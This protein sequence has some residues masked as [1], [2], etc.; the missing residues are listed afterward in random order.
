[1]EYQPKQDESTDY[2][3]PADDLKY[4]NIALNE[5]C[6]SPPKPTNF[7]IGA[8]LVAVHPEASTTELL[9]S[10]YT[11]ECEGNTHAEQCCFIKLAAQC[12]CPESELG[13][14]LP[15]HT[16]LYTTMEPC[17]NRSV[18]NTPCVDRILSLRRADGGVAIEKVFVGVVEPGTFV[19]VNQGRQ[20]LED[21]GIE[22]VKVGGLDKEILKVARAGHE[23]E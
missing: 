20:R 13:L 22:V 14:H 8:C 15:G 21:A 3:L 17:N 12:Q 19:S 23:R 9:V 10:G 18:G 5:A 16:W 2:S 1:M 6:K 11:L 7:C 4:M